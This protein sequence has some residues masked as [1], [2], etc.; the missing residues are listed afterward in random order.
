[1][2]FQIFN[3]YLSINRCH[4]YC[5]LCNRY[6]NH[7]N[8]S[9]TKSPVWDHYKTIGGSYRLDRCPKCNSIGRERMVQLFLKEGEKYKGK[10][11]LHVAP[12]ISLSNWLQNKKCKYVAIDKKEGYYANK[13]P[14]NVKNADITH[15]EFCDESFDIIICNHVL[16]HVI[17]DHQAIKELYRVLRYGGFAIIQVPMALDLENTIENIAASEEEKFNL[18]GHIDHKRLYG[19]KSFKT[20][21]EHYGFNV[22]PTAIRFNAIKYG[23][24][25]EEK[26]MV[27]YK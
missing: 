2:E 17:D 15:L 22:V 26:L 1:M 13:Y 21:L 19:Y 3:I 11:I 9:G 12:E 20:L 8:D 7:F 27:C 25:V 14:A 4:Y 24:D 18:Y 5:S 10:D 6:I 23:F 16:E